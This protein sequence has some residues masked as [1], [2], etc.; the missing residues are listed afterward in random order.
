MAQILERHIAIDPVVCHGRPHI[1]G[2]RIR[3]QDIVVWH[4]HLGQTVHEICAEYQLHPAQVYAALSFYFDNKTLLDKAIATDQNS[5][6]RLKQSS[7]SLLPKN[8]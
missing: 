1:A 8:V 5:F 2:H 4:E 7:L 3:V 6:E